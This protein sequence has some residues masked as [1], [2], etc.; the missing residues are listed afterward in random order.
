MFL[1]MDKNWNKFAKSI[2]DF[3]PKKGLK[4][5]EIHTKFVKLLLFDEFQ[6]KKIIKSFNL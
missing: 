3:E 6:I 2:I 4:L 5:V 1:S